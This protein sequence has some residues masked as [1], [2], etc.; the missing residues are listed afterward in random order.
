MKTIFIII[1]TFFA[2]T[3]VI[4]QGILINEFMAKNNA[5]IQDEDGDYSDWIE[6]YNSTNSTINLMNFGL[7][8]EYNSLNK[9]TFPNIT[10]QAHS[11]LLV[12]ASSKNRIDPTELHANFK[13]T[14]SGEE[15]YLSNNL[16]T[17]I[18]QTNSVNLSS[19]E[20]YGRIPDGE[21]NWIV[22]NTPS[23][24]SSNNNSN[25][26]IFSNQEGF[27]TTSFS[28]KINSRLDDKI[29]YTL[30]GDIPTENSKIFTDSLFID[31]VNLEPNIIS[32]IP[33]T[34]AQELISYKAWE[35]PSEHIDKATILRCA[36]FS[37]G[38]RTSKIYTKTFFVEEE[39]A[40]K[41]TIPIISLVTEKTNLFNPDSGI[42][43]PG[44]NYDSNSPEWTGNYF[45]HGDDWERDI[46]IE[47]FENDG[48]LGF[49]QDAGV[50]IHGGKTRHAS[51]KSL[52]LYA[53]N[54][55][56]EKYFNKQLLPH[57]QVNKY[58]RF[59]LRTTMG[60]WKGET[61]IKDVLAQNIS[62]SLD[63]DYQEFQ[64]VIV[65]INGEYWGIHTIRDRIDERYIEYT[66]GV[67]KDSVEF[68]E[69]E[70]SAYKSLIEFIGNNNL[71]YNSNYDYVKTRIDVN[72][73]IDYIIAELFFTNIDWPYNNVKI[74]RKV[75]DGKWRWVFY[76]LDAG[77][78]N[79]N[80]SM[81]YRA[82]LVENS[83]EADDQPP[84]FLFHNLL[85]NDKFQSLFINRY[86]EILNNEFH[87]EIMTSRLDSIKAIYNPE[88]ANHISRWNYPKS[89]NSWEKDVEKDLLHF[90]EERPC[91]VR[92]KIMT[93]FS[94]TEF[95]FDCTRNF[96]IVDNHLILAPNPNNGIF[97]LFNDSL[98]LV[99]A[100]VKIVN[101]NSQVIDYEN[102]INL[103]KNEKKYF[104]F[105]H[106]PS[107]IYILHIKSNNYSEQRKIIIVN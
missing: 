52:R 13:I 4:G 82:I 30:N 89:V 66:H 11:Y 90:I 2:V 1:I 33:T 26:L 92:N 60:A 54:E 29:Y 35:L 27:Y 77:F 7:S 45:M 43:V 61:I 8:D 50:R 57:R 48:S 96:E 95:D 10:I 73:F 39:I 87:T 17:I 88:I 94:L 40:T 106:L 72:N 58:K 91:V 16:G 98:D 65:Y 23:P 78:W 31:N 12:F 84:T 34:P 51:Q 85:K 83:L 81:L 63:I 46:H 44:V 21:T 97:F 15:L 6:L 49:S 37:K 75:P 107:N 53:R 76:D 70:N 25:Q 104:D 56:G 105:S 67:D 62:A 55:Y 102:N 93:I 3:N 86:A 32:E 71:K 74:W 22:I 101:I 100:S 64:P 14:S 69:F 79:V 68:K 36:S 38:V 80:Y 18:D 47:Y 28:L 5:T 19:D 24:N 99:N 103:M 9:W 42:Y 20:S 41:Y 59:I